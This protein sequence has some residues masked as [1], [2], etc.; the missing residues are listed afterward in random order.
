MQFSHRVPQMLHD[1]HMATVALLERV[2]DVIMSRRGSPPDAGEPELSELLRRFAAMM[3]GEVTSHFS[4]EEESLFP[5]L[6]E[7]GEADIGELLR[8]E[9]DALRE[10]GAQMVTLARAAAQNGF[11]PETWA[12]FRRLGGELVE[13]MLSHVQKEEMALL[14]LLDDV[15]DADTDAALAMS[16]AERH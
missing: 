15:V 1:E 14:P 13:R 16:H 11:G 8:E 3:E 12:E 2:E 10:V 9:H 4:F 7:R 5:L 6:S